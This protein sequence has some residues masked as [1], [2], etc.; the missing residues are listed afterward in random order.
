[1]EEEI[2]TPLEEYKGDVVNILVCGIDYEE[3]RNYSDASTND[4]MTDTILYCQF[5]H[6]K[7]ALRCCRSP[8]T[9]WWPLRTESDPCPTA[10]PTPPPT[11]RSTRWP[12]PT[13][14]VLPLLAEVIYDQYSLP[15]DYYVTMDM[16]GW[17]KW[18][19]T[20]AASRWYI[21]QDM[22][23]GQRAA[24]GLPQPE[25]FL[26]RVLCA[27][28]PRRRLFQL[29]S[30]PPEHAALFLRG[31]FK[32]VRSM[33][34]TDAEPAGAG[35]QQLYQD[36]HGHL[37]PSPRCWSPSPASTAPTSCWHRRRCS[38]GVP[39]VGKTDSFDGYS[40]VVPDA[41]S[42]AELL[43]TYFRNYTGPSAPKN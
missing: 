15:M 39:N 40:C 37:P 24:K 8:A 29:G 34:I 4:G 14:A 23:Y 11:T 33:G 5:R 25:W 30:R 38:W 26:G 28:P 36:G 1:M 16:Q 18:W 9:A 31:L 20:L 21:P 6:Q 35:V 27:L 7:G 10:R 17:W 2:K 12:C 43:N 32:R 42:I 22:S 19:I 3:G 13:A 41:G